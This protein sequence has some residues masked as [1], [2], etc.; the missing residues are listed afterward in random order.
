[1]STYFILKILITVYFI[2][3]K[4]T[5]CYTRRVNSC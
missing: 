1:M 4:R 5:M 2:K 3:V